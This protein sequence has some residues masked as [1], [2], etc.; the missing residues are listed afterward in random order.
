MI[1]SVDSEMIEAASHFSDW[2]IYPDNMH[3][4][5]GMVGKKWLNFALMTPRMQNFVQ[6][7]IDAIKQH[8]GLDFSVQF[9]SGQLNLKIRLARF[10]GYLA[11]RSMS[12]NTPDLDRLTSNKDVKDLVLSSVLNIQGGLVICIGNPGTGKSYFAHAATRERLKQ[13]GGHLVVIGDP[14]ESPIGDDGT[15]VVGTNGYVDEIDVSEIGATLGLKMALRSYPVGIKPLLLFSEVRSDTNAFDL[16]NAAINGFTIF[17]T[18]HASTPDACVDRLISWCVKGGVDIGLVRNML[19]QSLFGITSH[20]FEH[21]QF[22]IYAYPCLE[23]TR[24]RIREGLPLP[25]KSTAAMKFS[26]S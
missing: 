9:Q 13:Y 10:P 23:E 21:G 3:S 2:R 8:A 17:T 5:V 16:V 22:T 24:K 18:T 15:F 4:C 14:L 20:K 6:L 25:F 19:A 1:V 11:G 12:I 26:K 7:F